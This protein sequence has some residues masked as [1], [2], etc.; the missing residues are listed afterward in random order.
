MRVFRLAAMALLRPHRLHQ[1]SPVPPPI[2]GREADQQGCLKSSAPHG[3]SAL[4]EAGKSGPAT[5]G[6]SPGRAPCLRYGAGSVLLGGAME[7]EPLPDHPDE[8]QLLLDHATR[9]R[10]QHET[11][12]E[13]FPGVGFPQERPKD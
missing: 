4:I 11:V 2:R 10:D 9:C 5:S 6:P 12:L 1:V 7:C 13:N 3:R 8:L